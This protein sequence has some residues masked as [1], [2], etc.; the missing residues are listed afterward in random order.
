M[1]M[2]WSKSFLVKSPLILT[3]MQNVIVQLKRFFFP[4]SKVLT[5]IPT[6]APFRVGHTATHG[7]LIRLVKA[8]TT[9]LRTLILT[10]APYRIVP[11]W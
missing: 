8:L 9:K 10:H 4:F 1:P 3:V 6:T 2:A 5:F 11:K 7:P